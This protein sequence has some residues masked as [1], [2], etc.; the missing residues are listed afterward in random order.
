MLELA[1]ALP[2]DPLITKRG[3]ERW[4][5]TGIQRGVKF[6]GDFGVERRE[7]LAAV[8]LPSRAVRTAVARNSTIPNRSFP[9]MIGIVSALPPSSHTRV[10]SEVFEMKMTIPRR[11]QFLQELWLCFG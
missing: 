1:A 3:D 5:E 4:V 9:L 7:R 6:S 8:S 11:D 10:Y 2:P